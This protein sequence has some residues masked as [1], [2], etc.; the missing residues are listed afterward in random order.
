V[1]DNPGEFRLDSWMNSW[2]LLF[3][4]LFASL[5]PAAR[6]AGI[7]VVVW[8]EQQPQQRQAYT[9]YLGNQI[10]GYLR[11]VP[12]LEV[13]SVRLADPEQG[14]SE[15]TLDHCQVLIW[16]GHVK[17]GEVSPERA[18]RVVRRIQEGKL[19]LLALH[20]AH[21][22]EPFVEAM[23]ERAKEDALKTLPVADRG[24][25]AVE[26][27]T[28]PR[29]TAPKRSDPLTPSHTLVTRADGTKILRLVLP[30]CCFP[31]YR[32]DGAPSHATVLLPDHPIAN[33]LPLHFD[34]PQTEM[35]DEPFHV[36]A[37]DLTVFEERWDKAG[38]HFKSGSVWN[39]GRGKVCYFRPGHETYGVYLE[40][41]PLQI[42]AN[43]TLWLASQLPP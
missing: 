22:S 42:L 41:I 16:W 33:G 32:A 36:P 37:P 6:G 15:E 17:N 19:A 20:S 10:A 25:V 18:A 2:R 9:N 28:P 38:E 43:T 3:A 14:I 5:L 30:S 26:Y 13:K 8:D 27:E 35:Y 4:L 39:L 7:Q 12:G 23:R 31:A 40:P 29:F 24:R 1:L 34:I 21:W 11:A